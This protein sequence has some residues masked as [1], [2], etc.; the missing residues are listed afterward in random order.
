[1]SI[2]SF[3]RRLLLAGLIAR[4]G[5]AGAQSSQPPLA[6]TTAALAAAP[7]PEVL[8]LRRDLERIVH[9][10]PGTGVR[11][12][13][14]VVSV[15]RGDTLFSLNPDLPLAPASNLKLYS[16]AAALY[17]LGPEFHFS[18]YLLAGGPVRD[19]A[20]E[21]DLILYGTGDPTISDRM[22]PS[23]LS[24]FRAFADTLA[25]LGVRRI[26]GNVVGDGSY[27]DDQ[28]VGD[29]WES[30]DRM[31]WYGA[32][33]GALSFAE[34]M[35][36]LRVVPGAAGERAHI[37]TIP[38]TLGLAIENR[39]QT[40]TR[41]ATSVHYEQGPTSIIVS[42]Q[43]R[44]GGRGAAQVM[45]VVDPANYAAAAF[46][47]LLADRGIR[48]DGEVRTVRRPSESRLGGAPGG[49]PRV[50]AVHLSPSLAEIAAVTNHVSHNLFADELLKAAGR[51]AVGEGS[52]PAG[53]RA[54][55][56]LLAGET[57]GDT[58]A[59]RI[60]D[61]SGLSRS[62]RVTPR[63]T[64][65]LLDYMSRSR[66]WAAYYES[67]PEAATERGLHRMY[68]SPAAGN[69]RAK[70]GTIHSVSALSGYVRAADGERLLF[71]IMTNGAPSTARAKQT[72]N[73][74]GAALARFTRQ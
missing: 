43:V 38:A 23:S 15:D 24:V 68:G 7:S 5:D 66:A 27:F 40:V 10:A 70:T 45:P 46:R 31:Q 3:G 47:A 39:V 50:L 60:V 12:G 29:E 8:G 11:T 67:L 37:T 55:R 19:G 64:I 32:P 57:R 63:T 49:P 44:R 20:V 61:G 28:W 51:T 71:S 13:V 21:G 14:L 25:A 18:T 17:Y 65:Q 41:G 35:V 16:T 4:A 52:F 58:A 1:L 48:V 53:A 22:L 56:G 69:L 9:A 26:A 34:N 73:E 54:V 62:N 30:G 59:L 72:E 36:R 6:A 74:I 33:V 42:G 2:L